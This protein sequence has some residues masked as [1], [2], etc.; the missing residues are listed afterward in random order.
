MQV[1]NSSNICLLRLRPSAFQV[2]EMGL[3]ESFQK[4]IMTIDFFF[5]LGSYEYLKS[6]EDKIRNGIFYVNTF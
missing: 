6:M 1:F 5:V 2:D 3:I 4:V